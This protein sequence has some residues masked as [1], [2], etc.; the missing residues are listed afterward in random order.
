MIIRSILSLVLCV[1]LFFS[2]LPAKEKKVSFD[3]QAALSYIK[4]L[5]SDAMQGR[6]SGDSGGQMAAEYIASKLKEWGLEPGGANG[7][8]FQDFTLE[9]NNIEQGPVLEIISGKA[10][11]EYVCSEDWRAQRYSGSGSFVGDI[12][13]VGYGISAPQKDYD[14]YAGVDVKGKLAL[15]STDT[16]RKLED[17]LK[18]EAQF[19][20]RIKAAQ[21]HGA[22]GV[23]TFQSDSQAT[24]GY[25]GFRGGLKKEVYRPE[26]VIISVESKV[27]DFIFKYLK[28]E[29]RYL[30]GQVEETSK[31]QSFDTG[32]EAFVNLRDTLDEK[33]PTRNVLARMPGTDP[34]LKNEYV[35]IG[36]HMDHLGIDSSGDVLHG[37]NDNASGTAVVMEI[38]RIMKLN[39]EKPKRT[40]IFALW[41]AE[42][43][44]LLGSKYYTENPLYPLEK[45][46]TYINM[47]MVG[48]GNGK[49]NFP[50]I[51]YG[52]EIW[53]LLKGRLPKEVL[54]N[55][56]PSRGGPGGS[57]Q[58]YFLFGG[59]PAFAIMTDGYHF[60]Y[61]RTGDTI[62]LIKPEVL[63]NTGDFV[64]AAVEILASEPK[65]PILAQRRENYYWKYETIVNYKSSPLDKV[66]EEHKDVKDPEVDFQLAVV[67]EKEGQTG[68]ALRVDVIKNLFSGQENL[69]ASK[70]LVLY[71]A[72]GGGPMM[73]RR[74]RAP[75]NTTVL[76]GI[77]GISTIRDD[78][79]WADVLSKQG[80]AFVLLEAP[81]FLFSDKGLSEEG[82]KIVEAT[83]KANLLL[84]VGGPDPSQARALL[85][86]SKKPIF[87]EM[88][89]LPGKDVLDL[90]KKS[91][92]SIGLVMGK[93]EDGT[94][95]FKKLDEAKKAIG[96]ENLS[97]VS[98]NSLWEKAGKDQMVRMI[99]EMLKAKYENEDLAN[100]F[101]ATFMRVLNKARTE[102]TPRPAAFMPF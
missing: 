74:G 52:P 91:G 33:R 86:N 88:N 102:D 50:G 64:E 15:F 67:S 18:D 24:M 71:G 3:G 25:M 96:T 22:R 78:P 63:K 31:P 13:F 41:A 49:A 34:N 12:V 56:I 9:Y 83:G 14:D 39:Q 45:T 35:I 23:L 8:Y 37:A 70:G 2:P 79:R 53:D 42:E 100:L 20:N 72:G 85:E 60:K 101:S 81:G 29:L 28:T 59:V 95:Y 73:M 68:D 46:V 65:V 97:I 55:V 16:P 80:I 82:K 6:K 58:T 4:V 61:H 7:S 62:D 21:D 77:R 75:A 69:K 57:D 47:D 48:H 93:D 87:L 76:F 10:K 54:D 11:R 44:G 51:Y 40:L 98:E 30:F 19:Q 92:S 38:A 36:A 32:V 90:V 94:S 5:A 99:G 43:A 1:S 89:S 26:F 66:I 27:I 84:I 17:K